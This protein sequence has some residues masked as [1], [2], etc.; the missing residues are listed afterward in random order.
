[1]PSASIAAL[2]VDSGVPL[3]PANPPPLSSITSVALRQGMQ[4][5]WQKSQ[6]QI[7]E[8]MTTIAAALQSVAENQL[9]T[10]L[11]EKAQ[12]AAHN[13]VGSL[14]MFDADMGSHLA[15]QLEQFF[16]AEPQQQLA[17]WE[18]LNPCFQQLQAEIDRIQAQC[19]Q[20]TPLEL[21]HPEPSSRVSTAVQPNSP[22]I[23]APSSPVST[24]MINW[25]ESMLSAAE[26][27]ILVIDDDECIQAALETVLAPWGMEVIALSPQ[28]NWFEPVQLYQPDLII[29]DVAM[30]PSGIQL[31]QQLRNAP[32]WSGLPI[33]FLTAY[34]DAE[35]M[36]QVFAAG[37]DDFVT[38]PFV[39]PE[40]VTRICNRLE[41]SRLLRSL[42]ETDPLT[43][44]ANRRKFGED[45]D[46]FLR[47]SD[48]YHVPLSLA[49]LELDRMHQ[50]NE[51]YGYAFGD[52]VLQQL[53]HLLRSQFRLEDLVGRWSNE[54][55]VVGMYGTTRTGAYKRLSEVL[56]VFRRQVI[57]PDKSSK[58]IE[59]SFSV[60]IAD[61]PQIGGDLM[62]LYETAKRDLRE[63]RPL[64]RKK[65]GKKIQPS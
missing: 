40:L 19:L 11:K 56:E 10:T 23:A 15:R 53:G 59:V 49:L 30:E 48:R 31:C 3:T 21:T 18:R 35:T 36:H 14:G 38:K 5:I 16:Q 27:K 52:Q 54:K 45:L 13:L 44:V 34:S 37:A 20:P 33:L 41:R 22:A 6:A 29:L 65:F 32:Q 60:G 25:G 61:Y 26:A 50:I 51:R 43:G 55:F 8:R 9:E 47:L 64:R 1:A 42:S 2:P 63:S 58:P 24:P 28:Q 17:T 62:S 57:I 12:K 7:Q 39:G 4:V 46:K